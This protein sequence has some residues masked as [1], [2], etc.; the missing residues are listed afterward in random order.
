MRLYFLRHATATDVA[1]SDAD[2]ELTREGE[3]EAHVAGAALRE[4]G[5]EPDRIF[6]SP[7]VRAR[8]TAEIA[9]A[10]LKWD[11]K[12]KVLDELENGATTA[13]LLGALRKAG[14]DGDALLVGHMPSLADHI[15]ALIG[16]KNANGLPLG[17]GSI[18]CVELL[19][20]R[21]GDGQLMWLMRQKQL[22]KIA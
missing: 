9:A 8:Q 3:K 16:A 14:G 13:A 4:L 19:G 20:P 6:T 12:V 2:R 10:A 7:L 18:A 5:I 21:L 15:A 17:K 22:A 11:G 1:T